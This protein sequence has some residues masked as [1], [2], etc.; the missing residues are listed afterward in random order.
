MKAIA[1]AIVNEAKRPTRGST[2]AMIE[3]EIASGIRASATTRPASSSTRRTPAAGSRRRA[4][5]EARKFGI[6]TNARQRRSAPSSE[7]KPYRAGGGA[8]VTPAADRPGNTYRE[9]WG[10]VRGGEE[11]RTA[12]KL[13]R[14]LM[15][16]MAGLEPAK[17]KP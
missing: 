13:K 9:V 1:T 7:T 11:V 12:H 17:S 10:Y 15:K 8:C 4:G 2:P 6:G 16:L 14:N 5:V 3:N